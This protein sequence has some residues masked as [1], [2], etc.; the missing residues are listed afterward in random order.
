MSL[1]AAK[2]SDPEAKIPE[3]ATLDEK[4]SDFEDGLM[5][6][7]ELAAEISATV[8]V[9]PAKGRLRHKNLAWKRK[10]KVDWEFEAAR[11]EA[12]AET[13]CERT[14]FPKSE[15]A[16]SVPELGNLVG[17]VTCT[18]SGIWDPSLNL[19]NSVG[20]SGIEPPSKLSEVHSRQ[21]RRGNLDLKSSFSACG[22]ELSHPVDCKARQSSKVAQRQ[23][24]GGK[25]EEQGGQET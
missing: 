9:V 11:T 13:K 20:N 23:T 24:C 6:I 18:N 5:S 8:R 17:A 19:D 2:I 10:A 4:N 15:V 16:N 1:E 22:C 12:A 7:E 25:G 3:V 14:V 21:R